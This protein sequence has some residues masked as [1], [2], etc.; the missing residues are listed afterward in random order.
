MAVLPT[1]LRITQKVTV[2]DEIYIPIF[3]SR[4]SDK[5]WTFNAIRSDKNMSEFDDIS[6]PFILE[7]IHTFSSSW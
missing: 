2:T 5:S 6:F 4:I 3:F 7:L 1:S